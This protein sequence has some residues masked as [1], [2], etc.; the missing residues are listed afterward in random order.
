[1]SSGE[2]R[3]GEAG[4]RP[5]GGWS[6]AR[7]D[8]RIEAM[9][10]V[11]VSVGAAALFAALSLLRKLTGAVP[12]S[13]TQATLNSSYA[14]GRP[15]L[16]LAYQLAVVL[17]GVVPALLALH[18]LRRSGTTASAVGADLRR[19][20]S[21]LVRGLAL[22]AAIGVPGL[23]LYL[24]AHRLG[25]A[26]TVVPAALPGVWWAIPVLV[27]SAAMNSVLEEVVE[28]GYLL[29]RLS[30][31]G[32]RP[33]TATLASAVLRGC[34]HL[35]QGFGAFLGNIVM[36]LVFGR[37]FQRTGRVAPLVVAHTAI[38]VVAFVGYTLLRDRL[39]WLP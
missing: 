21:D 24:V 32:W 6:S 16:D 11:A 26:A 17:T 5:G 37:F 10:V 13:Q 4:S 7:S 9:L 2:A 35:Y 30:Q 25:L 20:V 14:P 33:W 3:S 8:L 38:D 12:L 28:I 15:W 39:G 18:L 1:M 36:G 29:T 19:P 34:Y 31:L 22:A 27:L 23:L